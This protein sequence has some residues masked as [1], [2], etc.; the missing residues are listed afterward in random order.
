MCMLVC[1]RVHDFGCFR[2]EHAVI[3]SKFPS[4]RWGLQGPV[5]FVMLAI[6]G[7]V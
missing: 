6:W 1:R 3:L 2:G 5:D 7:L 4:M